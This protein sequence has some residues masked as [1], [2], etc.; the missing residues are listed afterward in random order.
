[1]K[2]MPAPGV[3]PLLDRYIGGYEGFGSV[4]DS[5]GVGI[6][7]AAKGIPVAGWVLVGRIPTDEAF[8][9]VSIMQQRVLLAT[10]LF[11]FA[12]GCLIWLMTWWLLKHQL[13]PMISATKIID[14]LSDP[15]KPLQTLP[16]RSEDEIGQLISSFNRLMAIMRERE[17]AKADAL[18][19]LQKIASRV[20]GVVFQFRLRP[21]GSSCLPYASEALQ[22]IYRVH[23]D[24]VRDDASDVFAVVHPDDL[25]QHLA[26]IAASAKSLSPWHNEYRLKFEGEAP[27]WLQGSALPQLEP[28]GTVLWH[29]FIADITQRKAVEIELEQYR[30]HLEDLVAERTAAFS[31]AKDAAEAASHAKSTFLANMSHELRTPMNGIMGMV[32]IAL[33]HSTDPK[34]RHQLETIDYSSQHLL[35]VINDI[36]DISKIESG[37]LSIEKIDFKFGDVLEN[38]SNLISHKAAEKHLFLH[39]DVPA[40]LRDVE[41]SGDP[42]RLGQILLNLSG[43]AIKF[44]DQGTI[45]IFMRL[46][47]KGAGQVCLNCEVRDTGI[48]IGAEEQKRLFGAFE[49]ADSSMTRKYGGTGLGLAISKRLVQMMGGDISL[50]STLGQGST[51]RFTAQLA[52]SIHSKRSE[53]ASESSAEDVLRSRYAGTLVLL[54]EDEPIN[55]EVSRGLLED[56]G[57]QVDVANDGAEALAMA[58]QSRYALILMDM[59]MPNLNG[60]DATKEIRLD[61][62]NINTPIVAMTANAFEEDRQ[63][64]LAAGMNDHIGKPVNPD[65]LFAKLLAWLERSH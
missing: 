48:G 21:D 10:L 35:S 4:I 36:L 50:E 17:A 55:Q 51:F 27:F 60:V 22:D 31:V 9:P 26:S 59:Q 49:Q 23:P 62:V 56:I 11:T 47:E 15:S 37:H 30:L 65:L 2:P 63:I 57:L 16:I 53:V 34:L 19:L 14:S 6:F 3:N 25:Q 64:C 41:L 54:A 33:R 5:R 52:K 1:M 18:N 29:G 20:P 61:S 58:K 39:F 45:T 46:Y 32:S 13:L 12:A 42:L 40:A 44:T 43:N 38:L 28:D 24:A 7:S 8:A